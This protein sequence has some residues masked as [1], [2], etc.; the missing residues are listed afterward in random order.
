MISVVSP[1]RQRSA[2]LTLFRFSVSSGRSTSALSCCNKLSIPSVS[3]SVPAAC[4]AV[5]VTMMQS[6]TEFGLLMESML[7][8]ILPVPLLSAAASSCMA[9]LNPWSTNI[10]C[11]QL[12]IRDRKQRNG[13]CCI[14]F[15]LFG[16][17]TSTAIL[18]GACW[19]HMGIRTTLYTGIEFPKASTVSADL[20]RIARQTTT[21]RV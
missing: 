20:S 7:R 15:S 8:S 14:Y 3:R 12:S 2:S 17:W 13:V 6:C 11:A 9:V 18:L 16:P 21:P 19:R 10:L 1:C 5:L 4:Q